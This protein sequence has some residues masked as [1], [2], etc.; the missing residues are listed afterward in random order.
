VSDFTDEAEGAYAEHLAEIDNVAAANRSKYERGLK[1]TVFFDG[2]T[3][4]SDCHAA[5]GAVVYAEGQ[6]ELASVAK[7]LP[8]VTTNNVA[9]Y[10]GLLV[11]L[12]AAFILGATEVVAYGDSELVVCQVRGEYQARKQHLRKLRDEVW[13][14]GQRFDKVEIRETPRGGKQNKR[15]NNNTRADE[16]CNICMDMRANISKGVSPYLEES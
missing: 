8:Q 4:I 6:V 5:G 2:G 14:L 12:E 9:E 3:R 11:G 15:R 16:L 7:Y 10:T 13:R 1:V